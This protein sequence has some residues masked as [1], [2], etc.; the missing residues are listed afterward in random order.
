MVVMKLKRAR[1]RSTDFASTS[2][3]RLLRYHLERP[4]LINRLAF[5]EARLVALIAPSGY[6]KTTLL[7][8]FAHADFRRVLWLSLVP[9]LRDPTRLSHAVRSELEH[10]DLG[11]SLPEFQGTTDLPVSATQLARQLDQSEE[12]LNLIFD[13]L[14]QLDA[15]AVSWL[16]AFAL[17]LAEGHRVFVSGYE[18]NGLALARLSSDGLAEVL[19]VNELAFAPG[20]INEYMKQR[21]LEATDTQQALEGWP[22]AVSLASTSSV[23]EP[24]EL[25]FEGLER[26]PQAVRSSLAEAAVLA[27]WS[28]ETL[29]QCGVALPPGWLRE[30]KRAGLPIN[31]IG[32]G[33]FKPHRLLLETL[34]LEL[35]STPARYAELHTIAARQAETTG[36]TVQ[37]LQHFQKAGLE[38]SALRLLETTVQQLEL[39]LEYKMLRTTLELFPTKS[40][41]PALQATFAR[42][43]I[44]TG[45]AARGEVLLLDLQ[46]RGEAKIQVL[47][48][49]AELALNRQRQEEAMRLAN[50][51]IESSPNEDWQARFKR[52]RI[53]LFMELGMADEVLEQAQELTTLAE[54]ENRLYDLSAVLIYTQIALMLLGRMQE[55][56][57]IGH[58]G[59][60]LS[61]VIEKFTSAVMIMN[62]LAD[63]YRRQDRVIDAVNMIDRAIA[64]AESKQIAALPFLYDTRGELRFK[65]SRFEEAV[66]DFQTALRHCGGRAFDALAHS[67]RL[68]C[69]DAA[70]RIG[71][72]DLVKFSMARVR[73]DAPEPGSRLY[74][75]FQFQ[76]GIS[77]FLIGDLEQAQQFLGRVLPPAADAEDHQRALAFLAEIARL[78]G[79]L[80]RSQIEAILHSLEVYGNDS[81]LRLDATYLGGLYA[82]CV[83]QGWW[84]ERFA[85]YAGELQIAT[86]SAEAGLEL[87]LQSLGTVQA[88]INGSSAHIP[89]AK[90]A[91]LLVFLALHG[92]CTRDRLV[93]A[94]WDGSNEQ[95]HLEYF[96]IAV[97]RL[98]ASFSE[99][100][101]LDFNPLIFE[102]GL[103]SL[104]QRFRVVLDVSALSQALADGDEAALETAILSRNGDFLPGAETEWASNAR[105]SFQEEALEAALGLAKRLTTNEPRRALELY[106]AAVRIDPLHAGA[107]VALIEALRA[108]ADTT[109]A[110][111]AYRAYARMLEVEFGQKPDAALRRSFGE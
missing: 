29:R 81:I 111:V 33:A 92:P 108:L 28:E 45:D 91:E 67:I 36:D 55:S 62:N 69:A 6:G 24:G 3:P 31:P 46:A 30:V 100:P 32:K 43:L 89:L 105:L 65:Q 83:R 90:A 79:R 57:R 37:A 50:E 14:D 93:D 84:P 80:E 34:E 54:R 16:Q 10:F 39:R 82:E 40:L 110:Q 25:V 60:R 22:V 104:N 64:L 41:P 49:R 61:E 68:K 7:A 26:L 9:E 5:S 13:G 48:G 87:R 17:A 58:Q 99:H 88:L 1:S 73:E 107:H 85:P 70:H 74:G 103:Y 76:E 71:R 27:I 102:K 72:T 109:G 19:G 95:R 63:L 98:R 78:Q 38:E 42:V 12:N 77:A 8:A 4:H 66:E 96:K 35:G 86:I 15:A 59:L 97:R 2:I 106:R 20:E 75:T 23:L 44:E 56:E 101:S 94:L 47:I 52:F 51:G 21:G 11:F 53:R 18:A